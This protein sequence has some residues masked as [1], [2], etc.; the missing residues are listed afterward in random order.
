MTGP[1]AL[2]G[3]TFDERPIYEPYN[4]GSSLSFAA[5]GGGKTTCMTLPAIMSMLPDTRTA[6]VVN[7]PK[8][9]E[10]AAQIA[11][12]CERHG[13]KFGIIDEFGERPDLREYRISMNPFGDLDEMVATEAPDLPFHIETD[14]HALIEEPKDDAKNFYWRNTPRFLMET[15]LDLLLSHNVRARVPGWPPRIA[16]RP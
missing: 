10:V 7:D 9:G 8:S 1:R 2:L 16:G 15:A 3:L 12:L 4:A 13:R 14:T 11:P 6:Q 5:A